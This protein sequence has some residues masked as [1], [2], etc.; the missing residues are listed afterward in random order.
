MEINE[1][2]KNLLSHET[3]LRKYAQSL[4]RNKE[5]ANDLYQ[6]TCYKA[7]THKDQFEYH[8]ENGFKGWLSYIMKNTFLTNISNKKRSNIDRINDDN[9]DEVDSYSVS[10]NSNM[11]IDLNIHKKIMNK[12]LDK[13]SK[14]ILDNYIK[15]LKYREISKKLK[16]PIGTVKNKI[17]LARIKLK[18]IFS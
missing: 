1:F 11:E 9:Q 12:N 14:V 18:E 13:K 3:Y 2:A 17:F 8:H 4:T 6:D 5:D 15:G 7:L 10:N 16:I